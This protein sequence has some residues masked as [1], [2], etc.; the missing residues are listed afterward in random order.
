M[1]SLGK[2]VIAALA[3]PLILIGPLPAR[4]RPARERAGPVEAPTRIEAAPVR[5]QPC[6]TL[7]IMPL[8]D[9]I[10]WGVGSST[11]D[12]YR[13]ALADR[14]ASAGIGVDYVGS[15]RSGD[16]PDPD[17]EGHSGWTI[18]QVTAHVDGWLAT[19]RPDVILLHIGTNDVARKSR[20]APAKLAVL[21][22]RIAADSPRAQVFVAKIVGWQSGDETRIATFNKSVTRLVTAKGRRFHLV[23]Q[24]GIHGRDMW[25]GLHPNDAGYRKMARNWYAAI[26]RTTGCGHSAHPPP[27]GRPR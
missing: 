24:S 25:N 27:G 26:D 15:Q 13:A 4:A 18:P 19:Y 11:R 16:E 22:N 5:A 20:N 10:T 9:S 8:G 23:D 6:A 3:V 2:R 17:N 12:S 1:R 21:L 14:L 7:R